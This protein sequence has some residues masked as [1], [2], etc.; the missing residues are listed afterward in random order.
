MIQALPPGGGETWW[1]SSSATLIYSPNH[2]PYASFKQT[3]FLPP[4][5]IPPLFPSTTERP[6]G[7]LWLHEELPALA[8]TSLHS[9]YPSLSSP[10]PFS[11]PSELPISSTETSSRRFVPCICC[12]FCFVLAI[13]WVWLL[14]INSYLCG[15]SSTGIYFI[16]GCPGQLTLGLIPRPEVKDRQTLQWPR[17]LKCLG[18]MISE[19]AT[20][21]VLALNSFHMPTWPKPFVFASI[22]STCVFG[23]R[24]QLIFCYILG[25]VMVNM[26][27]V[28][29]YTRRGRSQH[30]W[31]VGSI[32]RD[33]LD[34]VAY[35]LAT[36]P[37]AVINMLKL[38]QHQWK[39]H[40]N[41]WVSIDLHES[42]VKIVAF[43]LA[44][45]V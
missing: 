5:P 44:L 40:T 25:G 4:Q 35:K 16:T 1:A 10:L 14:V 3:L 6:E 23:F 22:G 24:V 43:F 18:S 30:F 21:W 2:H 11:L 39:M 31:A 27:V 42:F 12:F 8:P 20:S 41:P 32:L 33:V 15:F 13:L 28:Q 36:F 29:I 26:E 19:H 17:G 45:C 34:F 38:S 37:R 9:S 7:C